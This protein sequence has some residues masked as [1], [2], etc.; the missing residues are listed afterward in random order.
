MSEND[1]HFAQATQPMQIPRTRRITVPY[2]ASGSIDV[3]NAFFLCVFMWI[4][5]LEICML[6]S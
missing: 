6:E 3:L 2:N 5:S 1:I 4:E